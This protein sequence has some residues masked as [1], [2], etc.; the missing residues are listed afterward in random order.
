VKSGNEYAGFAG[1]EAVA[2]S[3][4]E[5]LSHEPHFRKLIF[6]LYEML[7][8]KPAVEQEFYQVLRCLSGE[9]GRRN[10]LTFHYDSYIVTALLPIAIPSE[11][12]A[13]DLLMYPNARR[14]RKSYV[15][16]AIDKILLDNPLTQRILRGRIDKGL[17]KPVR[18]KMKPGNLYFYWGY[19]SIHTN[20]PCDP[21][22]LRSTAIFHYMNPHAKAV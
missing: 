5:E 21:D 2:G 17:L 6:D 3:G 14:I 13:G 20:E 10:S 11:G 16:N 15:A 1:A 9:S 18:I 7:S 19:R 12:K 4:L 22:K 8:G